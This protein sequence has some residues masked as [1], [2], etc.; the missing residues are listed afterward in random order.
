MIAKRGWCT[1]A[2]PPAAAKGA[3][4]LAAPKKQDLSRR[5]DTSNA[6]AEWLRVVEREGVGCETSVLIVME[7]GR[8]GG[9]GRAG[10][11]RPAADLRLGG[12]PF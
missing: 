3:A 2:A 1:G 10:R 7:G 6:N 8:R 11:A 5:C 4:A 9:R 12:L